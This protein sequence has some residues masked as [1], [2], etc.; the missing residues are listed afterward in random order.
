MSAFLGRIHYWLY[1]KVLWHEELLEEIMS[2]AV[3]KGIPAEEMKSSIYEK[4]GYPDNKPLEEIID[5]GNIHG[6]LQSK[7]QSVEYRIAAVVTGLINKH[8]VTI[9]EI[10]ELYKHNGT[11]AADLVDVEVTAPRDL[12]TAVFDFMLAGMPCDRVHETVM[13]SETEFTWQTTACLHKEYW[14][15][16]GG[17]VNNY[18]LLQDAW[19]SG[20]VKGIDSNYSFIRSAGGLSSIRKG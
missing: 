19:I 20:F 11:R 4:Y 17:D 16:I 8:Q 15:A 7:I 5:H 9:G 6:W 14:D 2:Y 3:S 1:N 18:Y 13:D 10:S 12:F